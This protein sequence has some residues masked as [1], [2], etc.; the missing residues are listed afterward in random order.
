MKNVR[1]VM[2]FKTLKVKF[3][4]HFIFH[5]FFLF[6]SPFCK[7]FVIKIIKDDI[8]MRKLGN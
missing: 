1:N 8:E 3:S 4:F 6:L 2:A 5:R 7:A